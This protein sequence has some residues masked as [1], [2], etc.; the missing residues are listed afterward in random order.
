MEERLKADILSEAAQFGSRI[1]VMHENEDL[2]LFDHWE[3]GEAL[4][5]GCVEM[6]GAGW[7]VTSEDLSLFGH[8]EVGTGGPV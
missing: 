2:S 7:A 4:C 5:E 3:V 1:L 6:R 8:W